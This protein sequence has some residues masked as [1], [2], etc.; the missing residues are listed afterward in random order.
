MLLTTHALKR[1]SRRLLT[2]RWGRYA[3]FMALG[4]SRNTGGLTKLAHILPEE[5][6]DVIIGTLFAPG[7]LHFS[8]VFPGIY[9]EVIK[10]K[11]K[12]L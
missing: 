3:D 10:M 1:E 9:K 8:K 11:L 12:Y 2:R 4:D 7:T 6:K 5:V